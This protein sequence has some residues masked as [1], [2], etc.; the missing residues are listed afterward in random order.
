MAKRGK[1]LFEARKKV[2]PALKYELRE[3]LD[4]V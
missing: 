1:N 3:A 2:D 4:L